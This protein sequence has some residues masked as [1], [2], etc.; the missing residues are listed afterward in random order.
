VAG[1]K[2]SGVRFG[3]PGKFY[4]KSLEVGDILKT[5][6]PASRFLFHALQKFQ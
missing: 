1:K 2:L 4:W 6:R 3:I 5:A